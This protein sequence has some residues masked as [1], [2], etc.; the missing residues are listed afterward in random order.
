MASIIFGLSF[1]GHETTTNLI[2]N[3]LW[4]LLSVPER[5]RQ[6]VAGE[7]DHLEVVEEI[8]R[9]D[10]SVVAWRRVATRDT[11]V[12]GQAIPAGA[13]L[14]L[15]LGAAN[16]DPHQFACPHE[17][18][19]GRDNVRQH[20]SFGKGIHFCLGAPLARLEASVVFDL[21]VERIPTLRLV[22]DQRPT[23]PP[24]ISFRGPQHLWVEWDEHLDP[25]M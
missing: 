21:L 19:P 20:L 5:W 14:M 23:Y 24:N 11:T 13:R 18:Q 8:L 25:T 17:F 3:S 6:L 10:S 1:A 15:S 9:L 22:P 2:A 12:G 16:R 4:Q 7:L